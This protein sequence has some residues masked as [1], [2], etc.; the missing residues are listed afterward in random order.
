M[1]DAVH[2]HYLNLMHQKSFI[3]DNL[4]YGKTKCYIAVAL[5]TVLQGMH[6]ILLLIY[7][8]A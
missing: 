6:V 2:I 3:L 1:N 7:I 4:T 5:H 8:K